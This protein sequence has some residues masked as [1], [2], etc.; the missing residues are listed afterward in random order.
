MACPFFPSWHVRFLEADLATVPVIAGESPACNPH[1][2]AP[3]VHVG[4]RCAHNMP[5]ALR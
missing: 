5:A 4:L 3:L 1:A 2:E